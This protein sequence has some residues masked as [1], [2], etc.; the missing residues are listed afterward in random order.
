MKRLLSI[1]IV[2]IVLTGAKLSAPPAPV[3][4]QILQAIVGARAAG[5]SITH[6]QSCYNRNG[7]GSSTT[8]TDTC[9]SA[10]GA[11][12][13]LWMCVENF[14]TAMPSL[15]I[16][17]DT[18][19]FVPTLSNY[20]YNSNASTCWYTLSASGG[21]TSITV[22]SSTTMSYPYIMLEE[23]HCSTACS[24]DTHDSGNTGY[25]S[26]ATSNS[27]TP[28]QNNELLLGYGSSAT[29]CYPTLTPTSGWNLGATIGYVGTLE[30]QIQATA[31]P[32]TASFTM[33]C[34]TYWQS[35]IVSIKQ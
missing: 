13:V 1:F 3:H 16:T 25:S 12:N 33:S 11:G 10:I 19:T 24:A 4:A 7:G 31:A 23:F 20:V 34:S 22:T 17:G 27:I 35:H 9:S 29:G 26:T 28:A 6:I 21:E 15:T 30:Y 18:G 5:G 14:G 32:V 2:L 8:I